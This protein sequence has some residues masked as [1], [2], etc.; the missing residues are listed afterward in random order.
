M[1]KKV[2][3]YF[4]NNRKPK[5]NRI[6]QA[7]AQFFA[8]RLKNKDIDHKKWWISSYFDNKINSTIYVNIWQDIDNDILQEFWAKWIKEAEKIQAWH[9]INV[10][11][12]FDTS[13]KKQQKY[14]VEKWALLALKKDDELIEK[15]N[16]NKTT[17]KNISNKEL[18]NIVEAINISRELTY[19]PA[20]IITPNTVTEYVQNLFKNDKNIS[21]KV[22][23]ENELKK[24]NMNLF[25]AVWQW[26]TQK[27]KMV[28]IE[29]TPKNN[30]KTSKNNTNNNIVLIWKWLTYDSGWLYAKPYPYMNDMFGDMWWAATVIWIMSALNNL[31]INKKIIWIIWLAENMPDWNSYKN[32]D[33]IKSKNWK[34]VYVWHTDAEWRLVLADMLA[35]AKDNYKTNLTLDFATLTW[36]AICATWEMY[37]AIFSDN[38][39]LINKL[40]NTAQK[41]NDLVWQ[42]PLD[43][44]SKDAVKHKL[45][46]LS[47]TWKFRWI[48]GASTAAAFLSN[49]VQDTQKWIHCDI[50]WPALRSEMRRSYDLPNW[51]WTW[52]MVHTILEYLK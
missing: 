25:V 3:I 37:T 21:I 23:D 29:Y 32:G 26:S 28:I 35:Y 4:S 7:S 18:I 9:D 1:L 10:N 15:P 8:T 12:I 27:P 38:N 40:N 49:F 46:D 30:K 50:A 48:L 45:A 13:L 51:M 17:I 6:T 44:Y 31:K 41:T 39:A 43:R 16:Q 34:T 22:L 24:E 2:K 42:L 19:K 14:F 5:F 36:A 52:A 33:I 47:N 20:N 11:L